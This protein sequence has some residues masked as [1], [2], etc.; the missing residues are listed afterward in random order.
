MK[1]KAL[2]V[3]LVMFVLSAAVHA[4]VI[5]ITTGRNAGTLEYVTSDGQRMIVWCYFRPTD[6]TPGLSG[7]IWLVPGRTYDGQVSMMGSGLRGIIIDGNGIS[8]N[9]GIFIHQGS[10][11]SNSKGCIVISKS[12]MD[13][14]YDDLISR[15]YR[16]DGNKFSI[17]VE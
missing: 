10:G 13:R 9:R 8:S 4:Q 11:P 14:I 6:T 3:L 12:D 16:R 5:T 1:K 15:G 17:K 7:D 2:L